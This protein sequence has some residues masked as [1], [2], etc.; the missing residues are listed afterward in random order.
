MKKSLVI[1]NLLFVIMVVLSACA[2][3][4]VPE[5]TSQP[6]VESTE[7]PPTAIPTEEMIETSI[8]V[9]DDSNTEISSFRGDVPKQ[10]E[11]ESLL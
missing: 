11:I 6:V 7:A 1:L 5:S 10:E 9:T 2:P 4:A 8:V 3:V